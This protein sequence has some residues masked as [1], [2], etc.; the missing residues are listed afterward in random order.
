MADLGNA[1]GSAASAAWSGLTNTYERLAN[2]LTGSGF[3]TRAEV[4]AIRNETNSK[5]ADT[6]QLTP[7]YA[8]VANRLGGKLTNV[9]GN[10]A[11][12]K[13]DGTF[14]FIN[15]KDAIAAE[16]EMLGMSAAQTRGGR[17]NFLGYYGFDLSEDDVIAMENAL[18]RDA[19]ASTNRQKAEATKK[20]QAIKEK[21]ASS[22]RG[23]L[24]RGETDE[25]NIIFDPEAL[26]HSTE[27]T[28]M[29]KKKSWYTRW[30][31][32]VTKIVAY[33]DTFYEPSEHP[34]G[35]AAAKKQHYANGKKPDETHKL[36]HT[37]ADNIVPGPV[38]D[39]EV[40]AITI[41]KNV[42]KGTL[43]F[44]GAASE[45]MGTSVILRFFDNEGTAYYAAIGH[46]V[47]INE[48]VYKAIASGERLPGGTLVG[49]SGG[50]G[51]IQDKDPKSATGNPAFH[52]HFSF[53]NAD[54]T[55]LHRK[56]AMKIFR[57]EK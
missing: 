36:D 34:T 53:Y 10:P 15:D 6:M 33:D 22:S 8:A 55:P 47:E 35:E 4:E 52:T 28:P 20:A 50:V 19:L 13:P 56:E 54:G 21:K 46:N 9:D 12:M 25:P 40:A 7:G 51:W 31:R 42:I 27:P 38:N 2:W 11:V 26:G 14:E 17:I 29:N 1:L 44:K 23:T 18:A 32:G 45:Q 3:N 37:Y 41:G 43:P 30:F 5:V 24:D 48:E 16:A 57:G 39:F 49:Q